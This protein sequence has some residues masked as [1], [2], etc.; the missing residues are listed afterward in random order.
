MTAPPPPAAPRQSGRYLFMFLLG[1]GAGVIGLV[2]ALRALEAGKTWQDRYPI[3]LMQLLSAHTAQLRQTLDAKRCTPA[4]ALPHLQALRA[5]GNDL[6]P[7]YRELG[8][9]RRFMQYAVEFRATLDRVLAELPQ[10]CP[11]WDD[12]RKAIGGACRAC[13]QDFRN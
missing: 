9:D 7:A 10:H 2:L 3:A 4:D 1:L 11:Q 12:A 6:E 5:L 13:H 8:S